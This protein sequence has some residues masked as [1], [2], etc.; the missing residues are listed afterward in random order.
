MDKL[1]NTVLKLLRYSWEP[2]KYH[3][4]ELTDE[5]RAIISEKEFQ[6]IVQQ[7]ENLKD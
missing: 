3:Y 1:P 7:I 5:E 4:C 6:E 2:I